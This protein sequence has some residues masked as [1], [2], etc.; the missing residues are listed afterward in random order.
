MSERNKQKEN[1]AMD[2]FSEAVLESQVK[3]VAQKFL[4]RLRFAE[5]AYP[6]R[7]AIE[8]RREIDRRVGEV[9]RGN[10][11]VEGID[12]KLV[13]L[14]SDG[15]VAAKVHQRAERELVRLEKKLAKNLQISYKRIQKATEFLESS[16]S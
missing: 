9:I 10:A 13:S 15:T 12:C 16:Y 1:S 4:L 7:K 2:P 6:D 8:C 3:Q 14:L 11:E 5:A